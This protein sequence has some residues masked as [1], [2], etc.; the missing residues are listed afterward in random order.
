M[1]GRE[2]QRLGQHFAGYIA[3]GFGL[4]IGTMNEAKAMMDIYYADGKRGKYEGLIM[5]SKVINGTLF[6]P[7]NSS[8]YISLN[9]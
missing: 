5:K 7:D 6:G 8:Y 4:W 9:Y 3:Y 1:I 2:A